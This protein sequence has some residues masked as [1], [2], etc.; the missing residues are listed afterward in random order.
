M[1]DYRLSIMA[2]DSALEIDDQCDKSYFIRAKSRITPASSGALEQDAAISDLKLAIKMNPK[3]NEARYVCTS[4]TRSLSLLTTHLT[5]LNYRKLLQATKSKA[6]SQKTRDKICF[7]GL[8]DRGEVYDAKEIAE[9]KLAETKSKEVEES[10]AKERDVILGQQLVHHYAEKG[11]QLEKEK[12]ERSLNVNMQQQKE[13][14]N[15][16]SVN[17]RNPSNR[18]I[19]DAKSM[20]VD[21]TDPLTI[22]LLEQMQK[23][24]GQLSDDVIHGPHKKEQNPKHFRIIGYVL[25]LILWGISVRYMMKS[26]YA[27]KFQFY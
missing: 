2:C 10:M 27:S 19:D 8:F 4:H 21:L 23:N 5:L 9:A 15:S 7:S 14:F 3:N 17:F 13:A 25:V 24:G 12:L 16:N 1:K 6:V 22:E 18:M 11:M 26:G 20:G